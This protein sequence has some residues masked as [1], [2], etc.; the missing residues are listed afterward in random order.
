ME[1][2]FE[3]SGRLMIPR[4]YPH[5][6]PFKYSPPWTCFVTGMAAQC[7]P[8]PR[9]LRSCARSGRLPSAPIPSDARLTPN[10]LPLGVLMTRYRQFM[11]ETAP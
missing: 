2:R 5:N 8:S 9:R 6:Q 4:I 1:I 10:G 11:Y 7:P 3:L